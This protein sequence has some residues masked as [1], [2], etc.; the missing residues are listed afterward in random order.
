[1]T[2]VRR[3][4][5][6]AAAFLALAARQQGPRA[7]NAQTSRLI[8]SADDQITR[9]LIEALHDAAT[10]PLTFGQLIDQ[11][12]SE[13]AL[14]L[15]MLEMAG[16]GIERTHVVDGDRRATGFTLVGK[17][18]SARVEPRPLH[19]PHLPVRDWRRRV[20]HG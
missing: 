19:R 4:P 16:Y 18:R 13:P 2:A 1:M 15:R 14:R 20:Q 5:A 12:I 10:E 8:I 3:A 7:S 11:G 6:G 9:R 17:P